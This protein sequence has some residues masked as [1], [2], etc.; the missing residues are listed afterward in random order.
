MGWRVV[1]FAIVGVALAVVVWPKERAP[2]ARPAA[3][4]STDEAAA[5]PAATLDRADDEARIPA[6]LVGPDRRRHVAGH[7]TADRRPV[8]GARVRLASRASEIAEAPMLDA[9]TGRDGAFDFGDERV[10][11]YTLAAVAEGRSQVVLPFD[12]DDPTLAPDA[13]EVALPPCTTVVRGTVRTAEGMGIPGARIAPAQAAGIP[14]VTDA[15]GHYR[16]CVAGDGGD[17]ADARVTADGFARQL[18]KVGGQ[19]S[20]LILLRPATIAGQCVALEDG[21]PLPDAAVSLGPGR[22]WALCDASARFRIEDVAPGPAQVEAVGANRRSWGPAVTAVAG[23]TVEVTVKLAETS[24]IAGIVMADGHPVA[25]AE[26]GF[27]GLSELAAGWPACSQSDGRFVLERAPRSGVELTADP[28]KV[29]VPRPGELDASAA[30]LDGVIVQVEATATIRGHVRL[31][32]RPVPGI[33]VACKG[34]PKQHLEPPR[35]DANGQY[36][37]DG[38]SP[39]RYLVSAEEPTSGS[40]SD[41]IAVDVKNGQVRNVDLDLAHNASVSGLV[42]DETGAPVGDVHV[43]LWNAGLEDEGEAKTATD[44]TFQVRQLAGAASY[45]VT[46]THNSPQLPFALARPVSVVVPGPRSQVDG[47]RVSIDR[48]SIAV[49]GVVV[50]VS[51]RPVPGATVSLLGSYDTEALATVKT[52]ASGEFAFRGL[53]APAY[54]LRVRAPDGRDAVKVASVNEPKTE[55]V[56]VPGAGFDGILRGFGGGAEVLMTD[57]HH[58]IAPLTVDGGHIFF[59]GLKAGHITLVARGSG[60]Y[61]VEELALEDGVIST[62]ELTMRPPAVLWGRLDRAPDDVRPC[63]WQLAIGDVA[64][65]VTELRAAG[66]GK[67]RV[68]MPPGR[69]VVQCGD[70][71]PSLDMVSGQEQRLDLDLTQH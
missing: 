22:Q 33:E 63:Q 25:G 24:R 19:P 3:P 40:F 21:R 28:Y 6:W 17:G 52:D 38:L 56:L 29:I 57:G 61:D 5:T 20:D 53:D 65:F 60:G 12:L 59:R 27:K 16:L 66:D 4:A 18:M 49:R 8:A 44:G 50:D 45:E 10:T 47:V 7:V 13:L 62:I 41:E 54:R 42:V 39:G 70:L 67:F 11:G 30:A 51:R 58:Y 32:G 71:R 69:V 35:S 14:V 1:L 55:I 36:V 2:R 64:L 9:V 26:V 15:G 31:D 23:R 37:C 34:G 48:G 46:V 68:G 43:R